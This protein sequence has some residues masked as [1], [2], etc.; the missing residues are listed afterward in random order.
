MRFLHKKILLFTLVIFSGCQ[1]E[2]P[3]EGTFDFEGT[4]IVVNALL[5]PSEIIHIHVSKSTSP[6]VSTL[7]PDYNLLGANVELYKNGSFIEQMTHLENGV[8]VSPSGLFP[9]S[10]E[11][12]YFK[13]S[14]N[15]LEA[16][17][18]LPEEIPIHVS[19]SNY[20]I[21]EQNEQLTVHFSFN[22]NPNRQDVYSIDIVGITP[23]T[24]RLG[25]GAGNIVND[26]GENCFFLYEEGEV[27]LDECFSG[28][29]TADFS[30]RLERNRTYLLW[31][32]FV[33]Y[34]RRSYY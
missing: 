22:D 28:N 34:S 31:C 4:K 29:S 27:F 12:Y 17:E 33:L 9:Q 20:Y 2:V 19:L 11:S 6:F 5:T 23:E 13:V 30:V 25:V 3:I 1:R 32:C 21:S 16:V 8:Y 24:N 18:T 7:T 14:H 10:G 15:D 26:N